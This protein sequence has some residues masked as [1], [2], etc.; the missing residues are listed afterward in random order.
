MVEIRV[1]Y[2]ALDSSKRAFEKGRNGW[3]NP[4]AKISSELANKALN[5]VDEAAG[6]EASRLLKMFAPIF[7]GIVKSEKSHWSAPIA[8][9]QILNKIG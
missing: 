6:E 1:I 9:K 2:K 4:L 8:L 3:A 7:E 5:P